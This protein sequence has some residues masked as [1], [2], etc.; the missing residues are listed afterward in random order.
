MGQAP[1]TCPNRY[2]SAITHM[3][4]NNGT[5][6]FDPIADPNL[7]FDANRVNGYT[8]SMT[9]DVA[10]Q[11][12]LGNQDR[13]TAWYHDTAFGY[14]NG[15]CVDD[16]DSNDDKVVDR[17]LNFPPSRGPIRE[18]SVEWWA[19][20]GPTVTYAVN[21]KGEWDNSPAHPSDDSAETI[22][23][24]PVTVDVLA[25]DTDPDG[26]PLAIYA[27]SAPQNGN[28]VQN[29]D[30]T[31]TYTPNQNFAGS[32]SFSYY[33]SDGKQDGSWANVAIAVHDVRQAVTVSVN[34]SEMSGNEFDGMWVEIW[35]GDTL[36]QSGS[37]TFSATVD[38]GMQYN[39]FVDSWEDLIFDHWSDGTTNPRHAVNMTS[40]TSL[41]AFFQTG[42]DTT[43][44]PVSLNVKSADLSGTE[45]DGQWVELWEGRALIQ[46]GFTPFS[47]S[48]ASGGQYRIF[49]YDD[50]NENKFFEHWDDG[51]IEQTKPFDITQD[52]TITA[53]F[54][55]WT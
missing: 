44:E 32:D 18:T 2:D 1:S 45:F 53:L 8:V 50:P 24:T 37:T 12:S 15:H 51:S 46:E 55:T 10:P 7:V 48:V 36:V 40:D 3:I 38:A 34:S 22:K 52:T 49:I 16:V 33:V 19:M 54:R 47:A 31:I 17:S 42:T 25:N 26:D 14:A 4:I 28:A 11:S 27:V 9:L 6:T 29:S 39:V 21:W 13:G 5:A 43:G 35:D 30:N 41:T 23:N 20:G